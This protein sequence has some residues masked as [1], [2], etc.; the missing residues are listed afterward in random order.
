MMVNNPLIYVSHPIFGRCTAGIGSPELQKYCMENNNHAKK[1]VAILRAAFPGLDFHCPGE[2]DRIVMHLLRTTNLTVD[3]VLEADCSI[4]LNDCTAALAFPWEK[5]SGV[6]RE[7][8]FCATYNIPCHVV[9]GMIAPLDF[10]V[11]DIGDFFWAVEI[12]R[13]VGDHDGDI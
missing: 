11:D 7:I 2:L 12:L 5:S 10:N 13:N 8:D 1:I 4:I 9:E 3:E 6:A